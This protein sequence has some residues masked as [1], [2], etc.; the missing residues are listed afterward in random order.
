MSISKRKAFALL[1]LTILRKKKREKRHKKRIWVREWIRRRESEDVTKKL[2]HEV[3]KED[4]N[5]FKGMFRMSGDQFDMILDK[6]RPIISKQNTRFRNAIPPET[7]LLITLKYLATGDSYRSLM[8]FF[9]VPHNTISGIVP[10]TCEAIYSTLS[11][12]YLKVGHDQ[13]DD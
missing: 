12:E 4:P 5:T 10:S 1:I 11:P 3:R 9:R 2:I 6:I 7:R 13:N 8:H